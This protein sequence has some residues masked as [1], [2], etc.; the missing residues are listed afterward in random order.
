MSEEKSLF[1]FK[2]ASKMVGDFDT[3]AETEWDCLVRRDPYDLPQFLH[4]HKMWNVTEVPAQFDSDGNETVK[5]VEQQ[6]VVMLHKGFIKDDKFIVTASKPYAHGNYHAARM[7]YIR[8]LQAY[9]QDGYNKDQDAPAVPVYYENEKAKGPMNFDLSGA[10]QS[11]PR[12]QVVNPVPQQAQ[13]VVIPKR[14]P[15]SL[16]GGILRNNTPANPNP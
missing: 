9:I 7:T 14:K 13:P 10:M 12:P 8:L 1:K 16:F 5:A 15:S 6:P 4:L 3:N 2:K 11:I